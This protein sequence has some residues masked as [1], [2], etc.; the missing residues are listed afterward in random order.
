MGSTEIILLSLMENQVSTYS[1]LL[2]SQKI[3]FFLTWNLD[4]CSVYYTGHMKDHKYTYYWFVEIEKNVIQ[5][6]PTVPEG[7]CQVY[8]LT[9]AEQAL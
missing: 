5:T 1:H 8:P 6:Q 7:Q 4:V 9:R 3:I 2:Q